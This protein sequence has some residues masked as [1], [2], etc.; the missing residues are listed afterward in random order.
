MPLSRLLRFAHYRQASYIQRQLI[1]G[2]RDVLRRK[3]NGSILDE[4]GKRLGLE[5]PYI[6]SGPALLDIP[7]GE[8]HNTAHQKS[9]VCRDQQSPLEPTSSSAD[10]LYRIS[11]RLKSG[12]GE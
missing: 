8:D 12:H 6:A 4:C 1:R 7:A 5:H 9:L 2:E 11:V 10:L 3:H